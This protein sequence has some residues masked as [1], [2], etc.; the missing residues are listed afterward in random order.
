MGGF[1]AAPWPR[2]SGG[3][4]TRA[5]ASAGREFWRG[6]RVFV[7]GHTGF[8]GSWLS[9]WL[10]ELGADVL[11]YS[12]PAPTSPSLF[13][14]A[15][16]SAGMTSVEA[17]VRDLERLYSVLVDF[18]PEVVFH[19]AAQSLV[20]LSYESPIET[21]AVN[22]M[23]TV[24]VLDAVRRSPTVKAVV[25]VTSDKCY[26]N[27]E[28]VWG[29]RES[30]PMGGSDPYSSSKGCA[31][32]IVAAYTRSFLRD[33]GVAV[34][35]VRAGN[36]IGG[37]DWAENRLIPDVVRATLGGDPVSIRHPDAVRPWQHVLEP[38]H[39]YLTLAEHLIAHGRQ[40]EGAWNFGP[41]A[42][43]ARTVKWVVEQFA[44]QWKGE[45]TWTR[46]PG[47]HPHEAMFL[48]LDCSKARA[49]LGWSARLPLNEALL[50]TAEWYRS[51]AAGND[52]RG[53]TLE[54]IRRY[55]DLRSPASPDGG[56][57][58]PERASSGQRVAA[59]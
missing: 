12:L 40:F 49:L 53:L 28:W 58:A 30:D 38:L 21:Y 52:I 57:E 51:D 18:A 35:S 5:N 13:E 6:K 50:W 14:S 4:V 20:Q 34:G 31:E 54:Q 46:D 37:G 2:R 24:H 23:G 48:R 56:R 3:N 36:V 26:E 59:A 8:K 47:D 22:V 17:D 41:E 10:Q 55:E 15:G 33:A 44:S 29:Y 39:G 7:T 25:V 19:L 27:R 9:L 42:S 1:R 32:L 45:P 11:G 16:V 43:D